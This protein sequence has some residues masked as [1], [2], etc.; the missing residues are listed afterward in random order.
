MLTLRGIMR[1]GGGF[2][3]RV[4]SP[5]L[6]LAGGDA[7]SNDDLH[8]HKQFPRKELYGSRTSCEELLCPCQATLRK[9]RPDT[10][11]KEFHHFLSHARG[12]LVEIETQVMISENLGYISHDERQKVLGHASE[13]GKML[14]GLSASIRSAA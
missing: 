3:G 7:T 2:D 10:R 6:G 9:D 5:T 1:T 8:D 11:P 14:N 4:V 12:S 13:L